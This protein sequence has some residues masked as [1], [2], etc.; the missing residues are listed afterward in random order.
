MVSSATMATTILLVT[1]MVAMVVKAPILV[2]AAAP[3]S[4]SV[5]YAKSKD[6]WF[7]NVVADM[8]VVNPSHNLLK[9]FRLAIL[10]LLLKAPH[11]TGTL[12]LVPLLT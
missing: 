12:T 1:Q 4:H 6:I 10:F 2:V 9:P 7:I 11:P 8:M 3:T 5:R